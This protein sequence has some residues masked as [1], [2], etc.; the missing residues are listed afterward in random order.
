[1][2]TWGQERSVLLILL[3][4][5]AWAISYFVCFVWRGRSQRD[6]QKIVGQSDYGAKPS[7]KKTAE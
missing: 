1:M 3:W 5:M 2:I 7:P 4:G 6:G